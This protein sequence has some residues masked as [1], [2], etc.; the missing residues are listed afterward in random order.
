[1][2]ITDT[3]IILEVDWTLRHGDAA[4][5]HVSIT[6]EGKE[7]SQDMR[8]PEFRI[9]CKQSETIIQF[10]GKAFFFRGGS[11]T[12]TIRTKRGMVDYFKTVLRN[13]DART[14]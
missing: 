10:G 9:F 13:F 12:V 8:D 14:R 5:F 4:L 6:S 7:H 3:P 11:G 1:M 2:P